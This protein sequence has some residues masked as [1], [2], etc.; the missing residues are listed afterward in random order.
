MAFKLLGKATIP[1]R[2]IHVTDPK[3][4]LEISLIENLQRHELDPVEEARALKRLISEFGYSYRQLADRLGKSVG[5]VDSRLK[6]LARPDLE[7]AVQQLDVGVAEARELAK[8]DDEEVR[9]QLTAKVASGELDR[10]QLKDEVRR[11]TGKSADPQTGAQRLRKALQA[12]HRA[13]DFVPQVT[14]DE[15]GAALVERA[16]ARLDL[17]L[18]SRAASPAR[19]PGPAFRHPVGERHDA[20]LMPREVLQRVRQM[21]D[22]DGYSLQDRILA[23]WRQMDRAGRHFQLGPW[24]CVAKTD[25]RWTVRLKY[26]IDGVPASAEWEY[27][28]REGLLQPVNEEARSLGAGGLR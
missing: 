15:E 8:V 26:S 28:L 20:P 21:Q 24:E 9:R 11:V 3:Q 12:L 22:P 7:K 17:L 5:Y 19:S 1:A 25:D 14:L 6:L 4:E 18:R 10:E 2:V 23:F 13:L 16:I 27:L